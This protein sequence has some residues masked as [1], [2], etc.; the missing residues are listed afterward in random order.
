MKIQSR[1]RMVLVFNYQFSTLS[2]RIISHTFVRVWTYGPN[3]STISHRIVY[4]LCKCIVSSVKLQ[5][6]AADRVGS[7]A[8]RTVRTRVATFVVAR[9]PETKYEVVVARAAIEVATASVVV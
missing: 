1:S 4:E 2:S 5:G 6:G 3:S 8:K 7:G 9:L